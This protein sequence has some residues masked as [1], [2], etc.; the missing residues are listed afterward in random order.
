MV[1]VTKYDAFVLESI[2][3]NIWCLSFQNRNNANAALVFEFCYRFISIAK[4]YFGKVDEESVKNNFVLIY[5]L[6]DGT[7]TA[8]PFSRLVWSFCLPEINDFGYPQNSEIDTLKTY[9]TTESI[10]SSAIAVEESSKITTQATGTTSW[11]RADVKYKKNEAFVDVVETVNLSMSAKGTIKCSVF[12]CL[13]WPPC[14]GT[15]LRADVDGHIQMRAY[16]SGT[17][18]CKFGLNDKLVID[19]SSGGGGGGDAVELDDCRFHQC[20]RLTEFD[21]SRTISFIPPD[22]EFELMKFVFY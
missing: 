12:I 5:E 8:V 16:L 2:T 14:T 10:V 3:G 1:A 6:I 18:E 15:V 9:I 7:P 22:G 13:L 11:R 4:S 17:P 21:S 19:K 20:V